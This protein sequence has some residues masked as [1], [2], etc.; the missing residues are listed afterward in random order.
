MSIKLPWIM[1]LPGAIAEKVTTN[2]PS[3]SYMYDTIVRT[4]PILTIEPMRQE[5]SSGL[6]LYSVLPAYYDGGNDESFERALGR[7]GYFQDEGAGTIP[8]RGSLSYA[9]QHLSPVTEQYSN[10]YGD[11]FLS[12][13]F[14]NAVSDNLKQ[15]AFL[16][17]NRTI[18]DSVK[19]LSGRNDLIGKAA[20]SAQIIGQESANALKSLLGDDTG[21]KVITAFDN[22]AGKIDFPQIWK[23]S[24]YSAAYDFTIRLF[25][26]S[27]A[28][29]TLH[30]KLIVGP[31][32]SLLLFVLPRSL[33]GVSY[34]W[35]FM[36]RATIPGLF[37]VEAGYV[38]SV[39][40]VK[41]GD[42]NDVAFNFR[43]AMVDVRIT[44]NPVHT[45]MLDAVNPNERSD[46]P[47]LA[48]EVETL[49]SERQIITDTP[50]STA[51]TALDRRPASNI[52][53]SSSV[54]DARTTRAV[55]DISRTIFSS[56]S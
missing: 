25:N 4:M 31:L 55:N 36:C 23:G 48:K 14:N 1:G 45:A 11:S 10:T 32:T 37:H 29:L 21:S 51:A 47:L 9:T 50:Y 53:L 15:V 6:E 28:N 8:T 19:K 33:D 56:I 35:P 3:E 46:A 5:L 12:N 41:G 34:T 40:V 7:H 27:P 42:S 20:D 2:A 49:R 17:G 16:T 22:A 30:E 44:I 52:P 39:S 18:S 54:F 24:S 38:S 13:S 26:P 43:P